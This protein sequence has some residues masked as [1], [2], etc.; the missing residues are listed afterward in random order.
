MKDRS[1]SQAGNF[2][3][4]QHPPLLAMAASFATSKNED[5]KDT[6]KAADK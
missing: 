1:G 3:N 6:A 5:A 2:F 4:L